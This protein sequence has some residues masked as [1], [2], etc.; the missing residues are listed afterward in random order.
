MPNDVIG[1]AINTETS[2]L[3]HF[4]ESLCFDLVVNWL[5]GEIDA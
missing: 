1:Q 5:D 3:C 4:G 2:D